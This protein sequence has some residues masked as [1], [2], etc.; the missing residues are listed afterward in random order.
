[1]P[2]DAD[3][4]AARE[5]VTAEYLQA[6]VVNVP[7]PIARIAFACKSSVQKASDFAF[8][9]KEV[10]KLVDQEVVIIAQGRP[11]GLTGT[12]GGEWVV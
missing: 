7:L 11:L 9:G 1:M 8:T 10:G 12:T 3:L 2:P 6:V 4:L 5:P